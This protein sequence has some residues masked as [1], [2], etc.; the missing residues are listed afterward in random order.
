MTS[1]L[2]AVLLAPPAAA[3]AA[4]AA[5]SG[6]AAAFGASTQTV[7]TIYTGDRYRDPF[8]PP[9]AGGGP[10]RPKVQEGPL[11]VDIHAVQLRGIMKDS[12]GDFALFGM[13]NGMT[14]ILRGG[15]L[16]D[17]R[18]KR[19]PGVTGRVRIKQKRAE[20]ITED[21]DVQVFTLGETVDPD[22][23]KP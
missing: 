6:T 20:L 14:L 9:S 17:E 8:L 5:S 10:A 7:S 3:Q 2:L 15:R 19:V 12:A 21:K 23:G 13:D 18:N 4:P 1:A 22:T 16:Y 11:V